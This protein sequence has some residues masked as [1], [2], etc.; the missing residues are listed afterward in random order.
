MK[1]FIFK[2]IFLIVWGLKHLI[3][4]RKSQGRWV[5]DFDKIFSN[6]SEAK[7]KLLLSIL[8]ICEDIF[9]FNSSIYRNTK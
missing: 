9:I 6:K 7:N 3:R 8:I 1:L 2:F 4:T 5:I